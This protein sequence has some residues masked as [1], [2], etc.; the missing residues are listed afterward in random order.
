MEQKKISIIVPVY[1]TERYVERCLDSILNQSYQNLEII[2]VNDCSPGN[3]ETIVK[4]YM[5]V[6]Q[7][8][9]Y[10][11][12][13]NNKGLF[14]ARVTGMEEVTGDYIAFLD[15]DDYVT[16]DY[17]R[18]LIL[19][20]LEKD[21][22]I[23]VGK[24]VH[25]TQNKEH[26]VFNMHDCALSFDTLCGDDIRNAYFK[27]Q[28]SCYGWHTVW[29]K[30]YKRELMDR[31]LPF[32]QKLD[33]HIIMTEDIAFSTVFL[34]F[35]KKIATVQ[36]EAYFYCENPGAST[37]IGSINI[38]NLLK[39]ISDI[40]HVFNFGREFLATNHA[41]QEWINQFEKARLYYARMWNN[42][43]MDYSG[44]ERKC[45]EK[46]LEEFCPGY[47][48][49]SKQSDHFFESIKT[50]W[51]GGLEYS[52]EQIYKSQCEYISF[53][54]F[55]T[56]IKRP[57][58]YPTDIYELMQKKFDEVYSC[59]YPFKKLRM[60]AE[61]GCR[62]KYGYE[63]PGFQDVNLTEIYDYMSNTYGIST[64]ITNVMREEEERIELEL[65]MVRESGKE[66]FDI[67]K[68]TGKKVII[69]SDMYLGK[70][71]IEKI[72][73]KNG[74]TNYD[75]L[76]LS[77]EQRLT[78]N[79]GDLFKFVIK[80]LN[81]KP[82]KVLHIGD[83]WTSDIEMP[84]HLGCQT[85]FL[86]KYIESFQNRIEGVETNHCS[87]IA[88]L[89]A[90]NCVDKSKL[91]ES[92]GYRTMISVIASKYFD[93][94]YRTFHIDSDFNIDPYF[95]GYYVVGMHLMGIEQWISQ[96]SRDNGNV[97]FMSRDGYLPMVG[98]DVWRKYFKKN[99]NSKYIYTSRKA[100]M[101][102]MIHDKVDFYDLPVEY[103][104]HSPATLL[105]M[106]EFCLKDLKEQELN[107]ELKA[108]GLVKDKVF[109]S[110]YE[111]HKF[112]QL[113][114]NRLFDQEKLQNSQKI[115][116][117]YM[118]SIYKS[119]H[120]IAFD[121]GYSGR[122]QGAICEALGEELD[123]LFIHSDEVRS[124]ANQ[125]KYGFE[126][127]NFYDF[128]PSVS[129]L[130][131]EHILSENSQ[132]CIGYK[133]ENGTIVPIFDEKEKPYSDIFVTDALQNGAIE[134]MEDFL[135]LFANYMEYLPYRNYEVS[136]PYEGF[137]SCSSK[138]DYS[139]FSQSYFEDLVYGANENIN[140]ESF[141]NERNILSQNSEHQNT[142]TT[143]TLS[144]DARLQGKSK[145]I[146]FII[147][148][149]LDRETLRVRTWE[150]LRG[151]KVIFKIVRK[152]YRMTL[153]H[154]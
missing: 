130:L 151:H 54:I 123:V 63:K 84:Q 115:V 96:F 81:T 85:I 44:E 39:N 6:D 147:Y 13:H 17:Y 104:N 149:N 83:T 109:S 150:K 134:F 26:Y 133:R 43:V 58:Y 35:A 69:T 45:I 73:K 25:E 49:K 59:N 47:H 22:D 11:K 9:K 71:C 51:N 121:M 48:E 145:I 8:V 42:V 12:H 128:T 37:D 4:R 61:E 122:I 142:M 146:K 1:G 86:P 119:E 75:K 108:A 148:Y 154:K 68:A 88:N 139:I 80:D 18:L 56:L 16:F 113:L 78:K 100:V 118:K 74:Y 36:N 7:R 82:E 138:A 67:A 92:L 105:E 91:M 60:D 5:E 102:W 66:L 21:A 62:R 79:T 136:L 57:L 117:D 70:P 126:I 27:Q 141:I 152:L 98:Y 143:G 53:D 77:S 2:V 15:S 114:S 99:M 144:L 97:L 107:E 129:G 135:K 106:C 103:R 112:I 46:A 76:Y 95:I 30:L 72:L 3:I 34:Y 50:S 28:C 20:A 111:Y 33:M 140:I 94:P 89:V 65:C 124:F 87:T 52:K 120:D 116:S 41:K 55:D 32:F 137:L 127:T 31:A 29:N 64:D 23:V 38:K 90:G 40:N 125:R 93:N 24:T 131:R 110:K 14:Q 10:I 153:K 19:K 101:P 132:S